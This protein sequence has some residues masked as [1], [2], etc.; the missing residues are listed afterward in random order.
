MG[1]ANFKE[2]EHQ[3]KVLEPDLEAVMDQHL[4]DKKAL[5]AE[6]TEQLVQKSS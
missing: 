4:R 5:L 3:L 2:M 6:F 1:D